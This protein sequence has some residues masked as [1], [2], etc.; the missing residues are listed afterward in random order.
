[1]LFV[2]GATFPAG[3]ASGY[4]F[5]DGTSWMDA[6]VA[7]GCDAWALDFAGY[8]GSDRYPEMAGATGKG[9]P[10][11]RAPAA[12]TQIARAAEHIR[13]RSGAEKVSIVAHSWGTLA[14]ARYA[15]AYPAGVERLV[16]FGPIARREL[17]DDLQH[18][19]AFHD[20]T[21]E[22]QYARFVDDVPEGHPPV[23]E[24]FER[25]SREYLA[26]DTGADKRDPP[27]VRIPGGPTADIM[28]SWAGYFPYEP[29]GV[30]AQV[31]IVRGEWDSLCTDSDAAWLTARLTGADGVRDVVI[32]RA[33]HLMHL[34]TARHELY[35]AATAFLNR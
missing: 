12:A 15:C 16:L 3:L 24:D 14:A 7:S 6:T 5:G 34:E 8:G 29:A 23:L 4:R 2:H 19:P 13:R 10:L 28:A 20:V 9:P 27:A 17:G 26:T 31:L 21:L 1:V 35:A 18:L 22:E 33:T 32:D 11:G 30:R 25:W